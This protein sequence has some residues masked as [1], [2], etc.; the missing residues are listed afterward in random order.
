MYVDGD[1]DTPRTANRH[2]ANPLF[3]A[4]DYGSVF[5]N[6]TNQTLCIMQQRLAC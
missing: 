6:S 3:S 1:T 5:D 4:I 2:D